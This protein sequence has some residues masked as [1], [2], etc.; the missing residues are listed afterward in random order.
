M[1]GCRDL[2]WSVP[3]ERALVEYVAHYHEERK[4]P[5]LG[6]ELLEPRRWV[7]RFAHYAV[8]FSDAMALGVVTVG[9]SW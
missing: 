6:N 4:H 5:G 1:T 7:D 2:L 8:E 9:A 3:L